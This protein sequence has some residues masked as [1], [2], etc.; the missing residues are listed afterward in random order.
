MVHHARHEADKVVYDGIDHKSSD[1]FSLAKQMRKENVD[2]VGD[3]P[4]KNDAGE[5]SMSEEAKQNV[6]AEHYERLLN[7]EFDWDPDHLSNEPP[8]EGSP[9][10][11][12]I[13]MVKKVISEKATGPSGIVVEMI[14][15]AGD[16]GATM[17]RDLA[18]A[19]IRDGKVPTD[20][21]QSFIVCL[22]KDKGDAL[23][24]GNYQGL[25]LTE[26]AMKILESIVDG[27]I[28]QMVSIDD[29]QF[30]FVPGR[31]ITDAIFVV[32][33]LQEKYLAVNK[34]LYMAF[35]DLEKAFD[36]VP[37]KVIWW[38]LRKLGVEE[39]IVRLVQGMYANARNRVCVGKGF[40]KE[41]E[42]K[43]GVHQ[44]SVLSPLLF[45][46]VL[47]SLSREFRAGVP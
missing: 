23:D 42:V 20:L 32:L 38:A 12:T 24:R 39:W 34:R 25:K 10:P 28:R 30:G 5:M 26:Q 11:I 40:S 15:A 47:E 13:D 35:V 44:G 14:K 6:W 9:I 31:G 2:V 37:G 3:K 19:I 8:L 36:R 22:N 46:I 7:V 41:F 1:I 33:Q 43:V 29:S 18:T 21:E 45:I 4:V 17:I 27:L 16:T